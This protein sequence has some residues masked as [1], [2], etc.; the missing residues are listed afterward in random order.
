[1]SYA[2]N[3]LKCETEDFKLCTGVCRA[4]HHLGSPTSQETYSLVYRDLRLN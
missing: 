1:M 3:R 4:L 2:L